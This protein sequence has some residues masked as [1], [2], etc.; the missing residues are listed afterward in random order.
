LLGSL[1]VSPHPASP[2]L[3]EDVDELLAA[4]PPVPLLVVELVVLVEEVLAA[5]PPVPPL[6][7]ELVV[8]EVVDEELV[9]GAP[10]VPLL[11]AELVDAA[12][13]PPLPVGVDWTVLPQDEDAAA[14]A[15]SDEATTI[16][17]VERAVFEMVR[18][19]AADPR[20]R[21]SRRARIGFVS[22]AALGSSSELRAPRTSNERAKVP[23][24]RAAARAPPP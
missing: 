21:R 19:M 2:E 20:C 8:M 14:S 15:R 22:R 3:L 16:P 11:V 24:P 1:L 12:P 9:V 17:R 4:A 5:A 10:P 23:A 13:A 18:F 6:V 7:V